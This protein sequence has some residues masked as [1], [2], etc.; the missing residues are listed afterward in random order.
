MPRSP[1]SGGASGGCSRH[2]AAVGPTSLPC[3]EEAAPKKTAQWGVHSSLPVKQA[4]G[5]EI[6]GS[7]APLFG[8]AGPSC[9]G[10]TV[11]GRMFL[12]DN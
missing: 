6:R 3:H 4:A 2:A 1:A 9:L 7:I 12:V 10:P 5:I 8:V 11:G